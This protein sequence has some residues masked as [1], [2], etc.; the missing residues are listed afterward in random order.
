MKRELV[1]IKLG[2]SVVTDKSKSRGVFR[3][4]VTA[5]LAQEIAKAKR[6]KNFD[7]IIAH[8]AGSFGHP[9]AA[10]YHLDKGYLGSESAK[11]FALCKKAMFELSLLVWEELVKAG[12]NASIVQPSTIMTTSDSK[13]LKFDTNFIKA[14]L[15]K[16]IIPIL[17]GDVVIDTK[18][19]FSIVSGDKMVAYLAKQLKASKV[20]FVSDVEGVFDKNPKVFGGARLISEINNKNYKQIISNMVAHNKND[21]SGEMRGKI[22][23]V[24]RELGSFNVSVVGGFSK[25]KV[26]TTLAGDKVGT[27]LNF[28]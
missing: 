7:L 1:I 13:I 10:K 26:L 23:T 3:R 27:R 17:F 15:T 20:I 18:R 16:K 14:L 8:G 21:V 6:Q 9:I 19:G 5:R 24:K 25:G 4:R 12:I 11:G 22:L 2:G 28:R